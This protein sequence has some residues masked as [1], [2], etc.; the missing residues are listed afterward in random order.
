MEGI[1]NELTCPITGEYL[2]HPITVPCCGRSFSRSSLVS[3]FGRNR[4]CPNCR[5]NLNHFDPQ[6]APKNVVLAGLVEQ[7]LQEPKGPPPP[8]KHHWKATLNRVSDQVPISELTLQLQ[9]SLFAIKPSLFIPIVDRSGS[10]SGNPWRQVQAALTHIVGLTKVN[11]MVKTVIISYESFAN[12]IPTEVEA[13]QQLK[14]GGGNNEMAAFKLIQDV[15]KDYVYSEKQTGLN[16]I[17]NVVIAFLTDGQAAGDRNFLVTEFKK[18]MQDAW[19]EGPMVVHS[20]GF[21][22]DCDKVLLEGLRTHTGT[23]RYAEPDENDDTLCHKLTSLFEVASMSSVIPVKLKSPSDTLKFKVGS[24]FLNEIEVNFPVNSNQ[25]GEYKC[26]VKTE[27]D[28]DATVVVDSALDQRV[29]VQTVKNPSTRLDRWISCCT[30]EIAA[31]LLSLSNQARDNVFDLHCA[32]ILQKIESLMGSKESSERLIFLAEQTKTLRKGGA[33]NI[34]KI[35]DLRFGSQFQGSAPPPKQT[36]QHP[37]TNCT[38]SPTSR[39]RCRS[40]KH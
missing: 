16:S 31:E 6:S 36:H 28:E 8:P 37:I 19:P 10:M 26:W 38:I 11:P 22:R 13:I 23:F 3:W 14:A 12:I 4:N 2:E 30:D 35:S 29:S 27:G 24:E 25:Q 21:G 32:L 9:D 5:A 39:N 7:C 15:L 18:M 17:S 20:V 40:G 33:V 34:G 1:K